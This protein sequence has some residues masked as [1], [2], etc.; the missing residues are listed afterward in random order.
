[1]TKNL[2]MGGFPELSGWVQCNQS[3][4]F[5]HEAMITSDG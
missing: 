3:A 5:Q 2:E 1:M 4:A